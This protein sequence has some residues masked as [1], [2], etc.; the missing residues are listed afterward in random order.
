MFSMLLYGIN[1]SDVIMKIDF[2]DSIVIEEIDTN[3]LLFY[4]QVKQ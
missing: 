3:L 4:E 2:F 1:I